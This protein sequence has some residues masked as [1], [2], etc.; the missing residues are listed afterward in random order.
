[1]RHVRADK[2]VDAPLESDCVAVK[3]E[4]LLPNEHAQF[5]VSPLFSPAASTRLRGFD[6]LIFFLPQRV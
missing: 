3:A 6:Q 4:R 2:Y 1:M 5:K